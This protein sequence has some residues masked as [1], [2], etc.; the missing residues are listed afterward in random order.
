MLSV[1]AETTPEL[2]L[3]LH[4]GLARRLAWGDSEASVLADGREVCR[5]L[6]AAANRALRDAEEVV[7]VAAATAEAGSASARIVAMLVLGR[8]MRER[9]AL[10]RE[11]LAQER[12]AQA[13]ER[14]RQ[15]IARL[16]GELAVARL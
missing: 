14:Q 6:L 5:R 7:R 11:Q 15:E 12:L 8:A 13:A 2:D 16:E 1:R 4:D 3:A 9:S 10:L